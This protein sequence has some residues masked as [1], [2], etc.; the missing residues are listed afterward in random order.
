MRGDLRAVRGGGWH[1]A[2]AWPSP[3]R[4]SWPW[5]WPDRPPRLPPPA[6]RSPSE[7]N[8]TGASARPPPRPAGPSVSG[9][10]STKCAVTSG[11]SDA[12]DTPVVIGDCDGSAAQD[13]TI[14]ADSTIQAGGKCLDIYRDEKT[15]KAPVELWTCTGGANQ[16]WTPGNGTL[17]NPVSGKC[18][19]TP[20]FNVTD[21]TPLVFYR[22]N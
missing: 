21:G 6:R 12:N 13:W 10:R 4:P 2:A 8:P 3:C 22:C 9:Y 15:N 7:A 17:V 20:R 11:G 1:C 16:Q 14:Q 5:R 19:D 18:L